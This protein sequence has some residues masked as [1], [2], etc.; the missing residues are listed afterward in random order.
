MFEMVSLS[1]VPTWLPLPN[2]C[3]SVEPA[4][5]ERV[6]ARLVAERDANPT[7]GDDVLSR[8]IESTRGEADR[9]VGERRI[10]TSWSRCC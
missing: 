9:S 6:V 5:L 1:M 7:D 10:G 2:S 3:A 4:G 8:L